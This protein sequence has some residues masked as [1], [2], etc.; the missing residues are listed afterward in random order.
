MSAPVSVFVTKSTTDPGAE[1]TD[2]VAV[3]STTTYYSKLWSGARA[4]GYSSTVFYTGTPTGTFTLWMTD[5]PYPD[6]TT[7]T[8][9]VQDTGFVPTNPAGAAGGFLDNVADGRPYHKRFKYV[10]SSGSGTI[11]GWVNAPHLV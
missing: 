4:V 5:K 8:D 11:Y 1:A 6:L 3:S 7:D 2:G 10:N 9:W